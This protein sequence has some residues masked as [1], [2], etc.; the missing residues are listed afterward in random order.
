M[1][2]ASCVLLSFLIAGFGFAASPKCDG[3][4]DWAAMSALTKLKNAGLVDSALVDSKGTK[5]TRITSERIGKD[6]HRQVHRVV[7][8]LFSGMT[9]EAMTINVASHAECSESEVEVIVVSKDIAGN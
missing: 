3:P 5:V 8:T 9:V 1:W 6:L 7:F 2:R 4:D